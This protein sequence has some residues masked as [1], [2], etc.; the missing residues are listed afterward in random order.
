VL[1]PVTADQATRLQVRFAL[2]ALTGG[3]TAARFL[4]LKKL[5]IYIIP[6]FAGLPP[7]TRPAVNKKRR[8]DFNFAPLNPWG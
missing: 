5:I 6:L 1:A 8:E 4:P 3:D 2:A 7:T